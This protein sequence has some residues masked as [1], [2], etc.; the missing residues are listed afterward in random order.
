MVRLN[1]H[2][3]Q[4]GRLLSSSLMPSASWSSRRGSRG[5]FMVKGSFRVGRFGVVLQRE[6]PYLVQEW[7]AQP[8]RPQ[9]RAAEY[10]NEQANRDDAENPD[11]SEVSNQVL[12]HGLQFFA[13]VGVFNWAV[14]AAG[15]GAA[16]AGAGAAL[17]SVPSRW[18]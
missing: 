5:S 18:R 9:E 12:N 4:R 17:M 7:F 14:A 10:D 15:A 16:G 3:H 8:A 6:R 2:T 11:A 13:A 1:S